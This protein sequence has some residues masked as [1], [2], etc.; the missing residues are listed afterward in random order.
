MDLDT[1][2]K[3]NELFSLEDNRIIVWLDEEKEFYNDIN[4]MD[5]CCDVIFFDKCSPIYVKYRIETEDKNFLIYVNQAKVS[6]K[7]NLFG[8]IFS[9][10]H[11]FSA[12][13]ISIIMNEL[14][15]PNEFKD[16]IKPYY[17]FFN[18]KARA[19][20]F[21]KL[22]FKEYTED[23]IKLG[24]ICAAL[25]E[26]NLKFENIMK[27]VLMEGLENNK[28]LDILKKYNLLDDFWYYVNKVYSYS[29]KKPTLMKL[30]I[31]MSITYTKINFSDNFPDILNQYVLND[32]NNV[33]VFLENF[34]YNMNYSE[35]FNELSDV[36]SDKLKLKEKFRNNQVEDYMKCDTFKLFDENIIKYYVKLLGENKQELSINFDEF[37][38][39]TH[40]YSIYSDY[41]KLI[42][43]ASNFIGLINRFE[44]EA[45]PEDIN[46]LIVLFTKKYS[47]FDKYYRKFYFHYDHLSQEFK[48]YE[49]LE[50]LRLLIENMY[51]NSFLI[52]INNK[53]YELLTNSSIN[54]IT[55]RKQWNFYNQIVKK[56]VKKH[57]TVVI[58]SDAFRY[59][60]A[61]ELNKIM[62]FD[63]TRKTELN[64]MFSTIPSYTSLGMASLLPH[65]TIG[66][67]RDNVLIDDSPTGNLDYRKKIL[68]KYSDKY[69]AIDYDDII[70]MNRP[71]LDDL[72]K[73][74]DLLYVYHDQ[75]DARGDHPATENEV[76]NAVEESLTELDNLIQ[77]LTN[78][79]KCNHFYITSDHGF[80][81]KRNK[82]QE[83]S[84]IDLEEYKQQELIIKKRRCILT[85]M[86]TDIEDTICFSLD[87]MNIN[88]LYVTVPYGV[89]VFK[90]QCGGM[91][92][93]HG[94]AALEEVIIP[95]LYVNSTTGKSKLQKQVELQLIDNKRKISNYITSIRFYQKEN[96]TENITPLKASVYFV[97]SKGYKISDDNMIYANITSDN[98]LDREF[99]LDFRFKEDEKYDKKDNYFLVI[100]DMEKEIDKEVGRYNYIIDLGIQD[101][102]KF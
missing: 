85:D 53:F 91:N 47:K 5:L 14:N 29:E 96:I 45:L 73:D 98:P 6:L 34:M 93:V 63:P 72:F 66:Y 8:D 67:E 75:V 32:E 25:K 74:V 28:Q 102:F 68:K 7:N 100:D 35:I 13:K 57:K 62:E 70:N 42:R 12:D 83:F 10:A 82:L 59:G 46:V 95:L 97:D 76:F 89:N 69:D 3:L 44:E 1:E 55:L 17:K 2:K 23:S 54:E 41:Y 48:E 43:Y 77:K 24:I 26:K 81:Y 51:S 61:L 80:I 84:K 52:K 99:K 31:C 20:D 11:Q 56:S 38:D 65:K 30:F 19:N 88:N 15:I 92:F 50:K 79:N 18:A 4:D 37:R 64:A 21:K 87:Y 101:G 22:N 16:T 27:K 90:C 71:E 78:H 39:K 60:N 86:P 94:G 58:I 40:Y 33:S 36:V 49:E 9:Y